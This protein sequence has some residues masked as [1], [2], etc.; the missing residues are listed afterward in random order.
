MTHK[1]AIWIRGVIDR[2]SYANPMECGSELPGQSHWSITLDI[3]APLRIRARTN[4]CRVWKQ[5]PDPCKG[6]G[7]DLCHGGIKVSSINH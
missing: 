2:Q 1:T 4:T 3:M 7:S 6:V 5:G